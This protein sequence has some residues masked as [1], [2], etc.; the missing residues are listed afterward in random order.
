MLFWSSWE[1]EGEGT[2]YSEAVRGCDTDLAL[3][4]HLTWGSVSQ[5]GH[6]H[7][8]GIE[9]EPLLAL[10]VSMSALGYF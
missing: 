1:A 10:A 2:M 6:P 3:W 8:T 4:T 9:K 5:L 7:G